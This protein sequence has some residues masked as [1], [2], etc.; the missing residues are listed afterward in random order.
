MK[1]IYVDTTEKVYLRLYKDGVLTDDDAQQVEFTLEALDTTVPARS[2][3]ATRESVGVYYVMTDLSEADVEGRIK[4]DW[5]FTITADVGTKT[6]YINVVTPYCNLADINAPDGTTTADLEDAEMFARYMINDQTGKKFGRR[7][8]T[9]NVSGNNAP[10]LVLNERIVSVDSV[11][12]NGE[13]VWTADPAYNNFGRELVISDTNYGLTGIKNDGIPVWGEQ[14]Y[15]VNWRSNYRYTI[16][17]IFGYD[18]VPDEI[19]YCARLLAEDYFCND[20]AWKKR[21]VQQINASDWRVVFSPRQFI[22]TGN[23]YVDQILSD[24]KSIG[25]AII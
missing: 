21:Y 24:F 22:G 25:M 9:I 20:T 6:D 11:A 2:G 18:Q 19:E 3:V 4:I 12:V 7:R 17:G 13:S 1:Q 16:S 8:R 14:N 10:N 23:F 5:T 15:T